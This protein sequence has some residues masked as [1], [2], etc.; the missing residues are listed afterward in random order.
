MTVQD[1]T[2]WEFEENLKLPHY[3]QVAVEFVYIGKYLPNAKG[4]HFEI[5]WL[6]DNSSDGSGTFPV[7][8]T[9]PVIGIEP[10]RSPGKKDGGFE[11]ISPSKRETNE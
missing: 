3:I 1:G 11:W 10:D 7:K 5:N 6:S 8:G 9:S 4:K 2:T